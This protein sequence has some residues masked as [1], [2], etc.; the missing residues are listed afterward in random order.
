[1]KYII[2]IL[3]TLFLLCSLTL[4]SQDKWEKEKGLLDLKEEITYWNKDSSTIRSIG[5]F[6]GMSFSGLGQRIGIWKFYNENGNIEE[7]SNFYMGKKHG[8]TIEYYPQ[9][10]VKLEA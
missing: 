10:K 4:F 5:Y 1:M 2:N 3:I 7:I 6:N 8:R 9:G